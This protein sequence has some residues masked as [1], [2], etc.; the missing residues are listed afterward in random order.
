MAARSR[1]VCAA[2]LA[3]VVAAG[4]ASRVF[5]HHLPWV[6]ATYAGDTLYAT[7]A[8]VGLALLA[9]RASTSGLAAWALGWSVAVEIS[10]LYRAP[11]LDAIRRTLPGALVLGYGFLWSDLACYAA[12][13]ALGAAIDVGVLR[14]VGAAAARA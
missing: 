7:M 2:A 3:A 5:G 14:R 1:L 4:L 8:L 11:W 6:V 13:V 9:P 10:Q 12:G